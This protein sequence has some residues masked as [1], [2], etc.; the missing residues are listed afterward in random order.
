LL[1]MRG[2]AAEAEPLARAAL[3]G[4]TP[5][6]AAHAALLLGHAA[7]AR[8]DTTQAATWFEY[9]VRTAPQSKSAAD[10]RAALG[11]LGRS[12]VAV[13]LPVADAVGAR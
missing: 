1:L 3:D 9:A 2:A 6:L 5:D 8:N 7:L 11:R 12:S 4:G 10:A 13:A